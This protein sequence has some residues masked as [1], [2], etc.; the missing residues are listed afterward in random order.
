MRIAMTTTALNRAAL[1]A[2]RRGADHREQGQI[3]TLVVLILGTWVLI[4]TVAVTVGQT[5]VRRQ[6]A[7]MIVDAAALTG[8]QEQAKGLNAIAMINQKSYDTLQAIN[9]SHYAPIYMDNDSTTWSRIFWYGITDDWAYDSEK[10]FQDVFDRLNQAQDNVNFFFSNYMFP[11]A[12]AR[13]IVAENFGS[14]SQKLFSGEDPLSHDV[15]QLPRTSLLDLTDPETYPVSGAR[16]YVPYFN[17]Y[18]VTCDPCPYCVC[19]WC[20][21]LKA[22]LAAAYAAT[23]VCITAI[24][25]AGS[26]NSFE[27][28]KFRENNQS[29]TRFAYYV[30]LN[31]TPPLFGRN[32]IRDV[33]PVVV[34]AAAKPYGGHL[35]DEF[36]EGLNI[37]NWIRFPYSQ[38][39]NKEI[40]PTYKAKLVPVTSGEFLVAMGRATVAGVD[41]DPMRFNPLSVKH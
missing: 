3:M 2:G 22:D 13:R 15:A 25:I 33:P 28:G 17:N 34:I 26:Y 20:C 19:V 7:Q 40:S 29:E 10:D 23:A 1:R 30:V 32:L 4:A 8:A 24:T 18:A 31:G 35:G 21:A 6:Q 36:E 38:K 12:S 11:R 37:I 5:L 16:E 27:L 39:N 14:G 9:Y 41:I